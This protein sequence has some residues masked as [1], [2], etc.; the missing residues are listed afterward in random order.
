MNSSKKSIS[1]SQINELFLVLQNRFEANTHRHKGL[2][3]DVLSEKIKKSPDKIISLYEMEITGGEPDFVTGGPWGSTGVFCDFSAESPVG[4]RS[5]CYDDEALNSRKNNKPKGSV[6]SMI[7][8]MGV[9]LLTEE[10]YKY[11]QSIEPLDVKTDSWIFTP[12]TIRTLGGA[13]FCDRRY[14]HVFTFH[15]SAPSYYA[16]RGFRCCLKL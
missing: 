14:N 15:N 3:W 13:M 8:S 9:S 16:S 11:I 12:Y 2:S 10:E 5:L 1:V 4:R 7:N 6:I